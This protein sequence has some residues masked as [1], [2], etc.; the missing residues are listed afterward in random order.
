MEWTY[1]E[2]TIQELQ[3]IVDFRKIQL[4]WEQLV[5]PSVYNL[6]HT[7]E[8]FY[9]TWKSQTGFKNVR[10]V[11][12]RKNGELISALHVMFESDYRNKEDL[13]VT[14]PT[15][16]TPF[17]AATDHENIV[18][19]LLHY[20]DQQL[21][22]WSVLQFDEFDFAFPET[23]ILINSGKRA[24]LNVEVEKTFET[25]VLKVHGTPEEYLASRA[26][27]IKK[28]LGNKRNSLRRISDYRLRIYTDV[29]EIQAGMDQIHE[30]DCMCWKFHEQSDMA[31]RPG[32][33]VLYE[34]MA[35]QLAKRGRIVLAV[36]E[37]EATS[38]PIAFE[39]IIRF[40]DQLLVAKHSY[41]ESYRKYSPGVILRE[42]LFREMLNN[43]GIRTID[44]WGVKDEFKMVWCNEVYER[45]TVKFTK[46]PIQS[47]ASTETETF[48]LSV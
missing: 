16:L 36:L 24:G 34:T 47:T 31:S 29:A 11:A 39:Y 17:F 48:S 27:S 20:L 38:E 44:T 15:S 8:W 28:A 4:E 41:K 3:T 26:P 12:I 30:V 21:P 9:S 32:Q 5:T 1:R 23:E 6:T 22:N 35:H 42:E 13:R 46:T 43:R 33:L 40:E 25:P 7:Y 19:C 18:D 2:Y 45:Y 14:V 10:A 37:L